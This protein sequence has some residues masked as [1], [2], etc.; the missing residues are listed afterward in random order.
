MNYEE[1]YC[2]QSFLWCK[3]IV[4]PTACLDMEIDLHLRDHLRYSCHLNGVG[5]G[6]IISN[7]N[8]LRIKNTGIILHYSNE[9]VQATVFCVWIK[10]LNPNQKYR[11]NY[12]RLDLC[13]AFLLHFR[14][15]TATIVQSVGKKHILL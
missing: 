13:V 9:I 2:K 11:R 3:S 5:N 6:N 7:W 1:K 8:F 15:Q 12:W 4:K 14:H 10:L